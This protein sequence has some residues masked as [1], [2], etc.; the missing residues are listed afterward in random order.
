MTKVFI[1]WA[2]RRVVETT[3]SMDRQTAIR[4]VNSL[5]YDEGSDVT[6]APSTYRVS[7]Q[8]DNSE[9]EE[10]SSHNSSEEHSQVEELL[11]PEPE[12]KNP[13][14]KN[15]EEI[16]EDT[17]ITLE[18][19]PSPQNSKEY[20]SPIEGQSFEI[21]P[22]SE[23]ESLINMTGIKIRLPQDFDGDRS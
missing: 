19:P 6:I 11:S 8:G 3:C 10:R 21:D 9:E 14:P 18:A 22:P 4:N 1:L 7:D 12:P 23:E 20:H 16:P 17:D 15:P 13:E 5:K 2:A